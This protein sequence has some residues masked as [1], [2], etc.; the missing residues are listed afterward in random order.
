[1]D[2]PHMYAR[3]HPHVSNIPEWE[4]CV[5]ESLDMAFA[6]EVQICEG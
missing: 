5:L 3:T 4:R 2:I 6:L 1:M